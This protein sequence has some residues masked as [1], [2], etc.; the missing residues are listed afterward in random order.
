MAVY[1]VR[2]A[3]TQRPVRHAARA[4]PHALGRPRAARALDPR[5]ACVVRQ[6][7]QY[8]YNIQIVTQ[9]HIAAAHC[10]G[11]TRLACVVRQHTIH[12]NI[13]L[14]THY[15]AYKLLRHIALAPSR[16]EPRAPS[17]AY[18]LQWGAYPLELMTVWKDN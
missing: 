16:L 6:Y 5:L 9:L 10:T 1:I 3:P 11:S 17:S 7:T 18:S 4:T 8:M 2:A 14:V 13:H 15:Y 12:Y